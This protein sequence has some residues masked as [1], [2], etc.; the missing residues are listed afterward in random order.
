LSEVQPDAPPRVG[1]TKAEK[2]PIDNSAPG[3]WQRR[4]T[5]EEIEEME[6]YRDRL[7]A[8]DRRTNWKR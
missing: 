3:Y 8:E 7:E 6:A 2:P 5:P 4:A 1:P